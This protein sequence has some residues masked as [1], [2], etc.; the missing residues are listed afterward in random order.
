MTDEYLP[1]YLDEQL[2]RVP[3]ARVRVPEE[4]AAAAVFLA[5]PAGGYVTRQTI[6]VDGGMTMA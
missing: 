5:G 6:V 4:L 2:K 3:P 1:G